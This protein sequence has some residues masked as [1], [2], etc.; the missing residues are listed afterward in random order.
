MEKYK[1]GKAAR[2]DEITGEMIKGEGLTGCW[3]G[4]G[5]CVIW[6]FRV[7]LFLKTVDLL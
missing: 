3:T 7:L 2:E 5:G 6:P 1:N 4:Y